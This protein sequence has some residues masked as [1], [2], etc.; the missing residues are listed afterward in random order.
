VFCYS[1]LVNAGVQLDA[2]GHVVESVAYRVNVQGHVLII[3][4]D[5]P[6][7]ESLDI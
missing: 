6:V 2:L 4:Q 7:S 1:H 5:Y 3:I